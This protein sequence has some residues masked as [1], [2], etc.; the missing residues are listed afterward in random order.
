MLESVR[1]STF[2]HTKK[3]TRCTL[4]SF[5]SPFVFKLTLKISLCKD[6]RKILNVHLSTYNLYSQIELSLYGCLIFQ[7][8]LS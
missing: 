2:E 5:F 7:I 1:K 4:V 6:F 8:Y 3:E